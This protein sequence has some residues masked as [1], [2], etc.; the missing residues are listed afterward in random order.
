[1]RSRDGGRHRRMGNVRVPP[2][3]SWTLSGSLRRRQ[4]QAWAKCSAW[5][6]QQLAGREP[7]LQVLVCLADLTQPTHIGQRSGDIEPAH[8]PPNTSPARES[9][10]SRPAVWVS[11]TRPGEEERP[12]HQAEWGRTEGTGPLDAT[13]GRAC[14]ASSPPA[15]LPALERRPTHAAEADVQLTR[16]RDAG[17]SGTVQSHAAQM[18]SAPCGC[19]ERRQAW[20]GKLKEFDHPCWIADHSPSRGWKTTFTRLPGM[21]RA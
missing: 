1:M 15:G 10:S 11:E 17:D 12:G 20:R 5:Q 3:M 8:R 2:D 21:L 9:N 19:G 14:H 7:A 13:W 18:N 6:G 16:P 4:A